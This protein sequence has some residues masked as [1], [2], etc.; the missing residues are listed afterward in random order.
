MTKSSPQQAEAVWLAAH[1]L[2]E[3]NPHNEAWD[4]GTGIAIWE[5]GLKP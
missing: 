2:T 5:C 1:K 3:E 4:V